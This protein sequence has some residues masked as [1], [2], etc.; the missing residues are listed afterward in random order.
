MKK[1]IKVQCM[2]RAFLARRR[3]EKNKSDKGKSAYKSKSLKKINRN[4]KNPY[5]P[6]T[7]QQKRRQAAKAIGMTEDAAAIKIQKGKP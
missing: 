5:P 3:I 7:E 2:M 4:H 1:I 6:V